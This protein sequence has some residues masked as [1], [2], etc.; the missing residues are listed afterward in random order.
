MELRHLRSFLAVAEEL[1]F[2]RRAVRLGS[3]Q[4]PLRQQTQRL[5][6][7]LGV[8]PRCARRV[9]ASAPDRSAL[10]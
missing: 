1:H 2:G 3:A 6:A 8:K 4:S 10:R 5:E 7:A 9:P